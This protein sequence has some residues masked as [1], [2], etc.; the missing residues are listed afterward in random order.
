MPSLRHLIAAGACIPV[1]ALAVAGCGSDGATG[2]AP[3]AKYTPTDSALLVE[4]NTAAAG[5]GELRDMLDNWDDIRA[6]LDELED[7]PE[8]GRLK[9]LLGGDMVV[10]GIQQ[11]ATKT[12]D[13]QIPDDIA[14]ALDSAGTMQTVIAL[15]V[16]SGAG[17]DAYLKALGESDTT[18]AGAK[19]WQDGD[20]F[21]SAPEGA[22]VA[23]TD[24]AAL[25][26]ALRGG[27]PAPD[28]AEAIAAQPADDMMRGA[29]LPQAI[30]AGV[31]GIQLADDALRTG[32]YAFT[33]NATANAVSMS[34]QAPEDSP[35][36]GAQFT[37]TLWKEMP[38]GTKAYLG[39]SDLAGTVARAVAQAQAGEGRSSDIIKQIDA[40][41]P[42][43]L[44]VNWNDVIALTSGE[45]ALVAGGMGEGWGAL[46]LEVE[47]PAKGLST[48]NAVGRSLVKNVLPQLADGKRLTVARV[49]LGGVQVSGVKM[50]AD[51]WVTWGLRGERAVIAVGSAAGLSGFF[52]PGTPPAALGRAIGQVPDQVNAVTWVDAPGVARSLGASP[53][54]MKQITAGLQSMVGYSSGRTAELELIRP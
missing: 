23:A 27:G 21:I 42:L 39:F 31:P 9:A 29:L 54:Y 50:D 10:A 45:H 16:A 43:A 2:L 19:A 14:S 20:M 15:E 12:P 46:V 1:V 28:L 36:E 6:G 41:A 51:T 11:K 53:A 47:D 7:T 33:A 37:P 35:L 49:R 13:G 34:A 5:W 22:I 17:R 18:V 25:E 3:V 40:L 38:A 30:A 32:P 48:L 44:G 4:V 8:I 26:A 24:K 52:A